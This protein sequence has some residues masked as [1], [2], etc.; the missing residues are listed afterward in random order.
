MNSNLIDSLGLG[1]IDISYIFIGIIGVIFILFIMNIVLMVKIKKLKKKHEKF[2]QGKNAKSLEDKIVKL[3]EKCDAI[4]NVSHKNKKDI[5]V[6]YKKIEQGFQKIGIVKYDAFN[7]MGGKLS[8]CI[9]LLN[10]HNNG[11]II[12]SVHSPEGC[13]SYT[14]EIE[15]GKCDIDLGEEELKALNMAIGES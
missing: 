2:M 14:K 9:T 12:N 13:Y 5:Q 7:E 15:N 10:E 6:L 11:F 3:F 1:T 8:Y 4:E